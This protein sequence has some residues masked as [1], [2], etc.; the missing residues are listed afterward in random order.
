MANKNYLAIDLGATSGR[1]ILATYDGVKLT[2]QELTRFKHPMIPLG[3]HQF[4]NLPEI[5]RAHV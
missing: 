2:M 3:G 5:G 1:S 4:W